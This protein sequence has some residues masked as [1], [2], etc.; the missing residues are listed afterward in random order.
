LTEELLKTGAKIK[1]LSYYKSFNSWGWLEDVASLDRIEV[2]TGDIRDVGFIEDATKDTDIIFHLGALI[3]I[4]YSYLAPQSYAETNVLGTL[5]ICQAG[6]KNSV[7]KIIHTSSSEVYGTA[8]YVPIDEE[9]PLQP[10]SPYSAT[11][12]GADAIAESFYRS[13]ALPVCIARPFNTYGP[14]QSA[15]AVIPTIIT[16]IASGKKK[17]KLGDTRPTR[18]FSYV[19][20]ICSGFIQIAESDN[21]MGEIINIGSNC[22]ISVAELFD[23]IRKIMR[24]N[25]VLVTDKERIRPK[26]SEVMR[27]WCDNSK[28]RKLTGFKPRYSLEAGLKETIAWFKNP[29]NLKKYKED[30][31]NV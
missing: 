23:L 13:F 12:I 29:L 8:R 1:A 7:K 20:D 22:E 19:K 4:P 31:Y 21:V 5:N 27:L 15:R 26:K 18:D 2:V 9:H 11:K 17:I 10:Q 28:I 16:Q 6:L 24:S 25:A 14:R 30:I 3:A